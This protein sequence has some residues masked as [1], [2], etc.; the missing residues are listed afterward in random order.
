MEEKCLSMESRVRELR[1]NTL[2]PSNSSLH[3]ATEQTMEE[4]WWKRGEDGSH[5][6][7]TEATVQQSQR[8]SAICGL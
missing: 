4:V 8:S 5:A 7:S 6:L 1:S 3:G 2:Q